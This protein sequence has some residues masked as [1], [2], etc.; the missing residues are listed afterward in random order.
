MFVLQIVKLT[1]KAVLRCVDFNFLRVGT[2]VTA[3]NEEELDTLSA[4]F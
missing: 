1:L 3:L 4:Y 2:F